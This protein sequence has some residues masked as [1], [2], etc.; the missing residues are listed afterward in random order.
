MKQYGVVLI[1]CGHIGSEHIADI[2]YRDN[3]RIKAVVDTDIERA[4][5]FKRKYN[6]EYADTDYLKYLKMQD[7]DIAIIASPAS[8]HLSILEDCV[9]YNKHVLCE[10]PITTN[11][12]DG[13]RFYNI[14]RNA[15]CKILIGHILRYNQTFIKVKE[16]IDSGVIG[17]LRLVRMVQN[18]HIINEERYHSLMKECSPVFDCGVHYYDLLQWISG[19]KIKEVSGFGTR[20]SKE[21]TD[22]SSDYGMVNLFTESGV[23]GYY[24]AGWIR[25][26]PSNNTKEFIGDEGSISVTL[27]QFRASHTEEGDLIEIYKN[28]G[29]KYEMIN[30][31]T[32]YKPMYRQLSAL[33][34]LIEGNLSEATTIEE[35]YSAFKVALAADEAI[36]AKQVVKV[37]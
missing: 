12:A 8:T 22:I 7:T 32:E 31:S 18:H 14:C 27:N 37:M 23:S 1:G 26:I 4:Q 20:V 9:K 15:E 24:E 36:K 13:E 11:L 25:G 2:Y 30:V 29:H 28:Q 34:D 16:L 35:A 17:N 6:A 33:I 5:E 19:A 21:F 10:K 3:V